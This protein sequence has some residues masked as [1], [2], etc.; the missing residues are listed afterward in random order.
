M[1][2]WGALCGVAAGF[3]VLGLLERVPGRS[4]NGTI[5]EAQ[6]VAAERPIPPGLLE[7][8]RNTIT[9]FRRT[10]RSVVFVSTNAMQRDAFSLNVVEVPRGTGS[11]FV[12]DS[13]GHVVTNY[14]VIEPGNAWSVTL[15]DGKQ[16]DAE[17]AGAEP[18]KDLA[19]LRIKAPASELFPL[20][21]GDSDQLVVGQKVLAIGNPFGLD[22]T[23]TTGVI[24]ALG[25]EIKSELQITIQDVIQTDAAINPGNSGGPLL[26]SAGRLIGLNTMIYSTS[27]SSAGIGFAVPVATIKRVVPQLVEHGKITRAGFGVELLPD[28]YA[29]RWGV[30][31]IIIRTVQPGGA[32]AHAELRGLVA[33]RWGRLTIGDVIVG[34]DGHKVVSFDDLFKALEPHAPGDE[35][36]VRLSRVGQERDVRIRLQEV[37]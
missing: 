37:Q 2:F 10:S 33:D 5:A 14:H 7:D 26:D 1:F 8:E 28:I 15:A 19:V 6:T 24:S 23:L 4:P 31:G 32:A 9:V 34:I 25:R 29:Q 35:V 27:G 11:G 3:A 21:L 20:E 22:Q 30:D 13:K 12:W 18:F 36:R 16:Y 17:L